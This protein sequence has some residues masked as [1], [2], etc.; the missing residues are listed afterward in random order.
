MVEH[1]T[2]GLLIEDIES[3]LDSLF[4]SGLGS[5]PMNIIEN[6]K[7]I[8]DEC[9]KYGLS[10]AGNKL[11]T[12]AE[13]IEKWRHSVEYDA[14]GVVHEFCV[15]SCYLNVIK[16]KVQMEGIKSSIS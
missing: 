4:M 3:I 2:I 10:Y 1:K 15:L 13:A 14:A 8:A 11:T 12:I 7:N 5:A 9:K 6:C 16:S